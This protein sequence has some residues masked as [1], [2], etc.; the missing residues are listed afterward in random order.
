MSLD[1]INQALI[2]VAKEMEINISEYTIF[3]DS[4]NSQHHWFVG[5]LDDFSLVEFGEKMDK[6]LCELNDDYQYVRKYNLKSPIFDQL[7]PK[8]FYDF[9]DSIGKMGA[10]N[11]MPRVLNQAQSERWLA[12]LKNTKA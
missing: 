5:S 7:S 10:Q 6:K 3:A 8:T 2:Q 4:V 12:F 1:N 11:K 9:L